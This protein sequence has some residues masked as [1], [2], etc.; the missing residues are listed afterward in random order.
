MPIS[1]QG[2]SPSFGIFGS[3]ALRSSTSSLEHPTPPQVRTLC[4]IF[5]SNVDCVF[6]VLHAPS[7]KKYLFGHVK[8]LDCSP[9]PGGLEALKFAIYYA[10]T[11]TL[12]AEQCMKQLG[13]D[14]CTLL[15]KYRSS[16]ELAL[17]RADFVN[18]LEL[19]TLQALV[20]FLV[21]SPATGLLIFP[22][23][24][25]NTSSKSLLEYAGFCP[26]QRCYS[27]QLDCPKPR[28]SDRDR[29]GFAPR[30]VFRL[31]STFS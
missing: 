6:K 12:N 19:S 31:T 13:E 25:L 10:A 28:Y 20:I 26:E 30:G 9:G 2:S 8:D 14:K 11:T 27:L 17:A 22:N 16:I 24:L 5:L 18:T 4:L 21:S 29:S 23:N 1:M 3:S 7:L 15:S